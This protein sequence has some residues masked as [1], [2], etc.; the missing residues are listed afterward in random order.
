[1]FEVGERV[2]CVDDKW[3]GGWLLGAGIPCPLV[4]GRVYTISKVLTGN[5]GAYPNNDGVA[6]VRLVE[7]RHPSSPRFDQFSSLRFRPLRKLDTSQALKALK[8]LTVKCP[9][10]ETAGH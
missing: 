9:P 6:A 7:V 8:D 10:L 2:V 5:N 3:R 1:M 4:A